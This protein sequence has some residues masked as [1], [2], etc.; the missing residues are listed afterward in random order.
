MLD[1]K[2]KLNRIED[3]KTKLNSRNYEPK[4]IHRDNLTHEVGKD[5]PDS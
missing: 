1:E 3:M 4:I 2:E 5:I